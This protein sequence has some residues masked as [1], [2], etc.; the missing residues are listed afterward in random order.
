LRD[1]VRSRGATDPELRAA[2]VR[3]AKEQGDKLELANAIARREFLPAS[4]VADG[5]ASIL[6]NVRAA[7]LALPSRLQQRLP[8]LT[9]HDVRTVD[10][11]IR[12]TLGELADGT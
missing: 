12:D 8:H 11:E 7:F 5:W 4:E 3:L 6:R 10:S 1:Q 9:A 2:K